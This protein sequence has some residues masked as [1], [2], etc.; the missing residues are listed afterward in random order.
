MIKELFIFLFLSC[1]SI[2][3]QTMDTTV[4]LIA[5]KYFSGGIGLEYVDH[6]KGVVDTLYPFGKSNLNY[7]WKLAQ[8][9]SK[10]NLEGAQPTY[11]G[12]S[13]TFANKGKRITF[14]NNN[15]GSQVDMEI[16]GSNEFLSARKTGE[17]WPHLLLEQN[18]RRPININ[19]IKSM[20]FNL[21]TKLLYC[22]NKMDAATYN[23]KLQT[24]HFHVTFIIQNLNKSSRDYEDYL[25]F[26]LQ[27][28]DYRYKDIPQYEA[29]DKGKKDATGKFIYS[30]ASNRLYKGNMQSKKWINVSSNLLPFFI[31]A[32]KDS[33]AKGYL[34]GSSF[35]DMD[36]TNIIIGW[37]VSGTFD[38]GISFKNLGLTANIK[39]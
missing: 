7:K 14:I 17:A 36:I 35:N 9:F 5:D 20:K 24:A 10:F 1:V 11:Y 38:C 18:F 39:N 13:V 23:P 37:E 31:D 30:L 32:I 6:S 4:D 29:K 27:I 25:W 22:E 33:Q 8:W 26:Q 15:G 3:S 21:N 12:D 34:K 16:F 2:Y 28:Y 19:K